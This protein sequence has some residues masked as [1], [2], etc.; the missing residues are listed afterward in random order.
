[1]P[2]SPFAGLEPI[3]N[4]S[5][6]AD[7]AYTALRDAMTGG[8]IPAGTQLSVPEIARRLGISRSPVREA[9]QRLVHDSMATQ[10]WYH[11]AFATPPEADSLTELLTVREPLEGLAAALAAQNA[12]QADIAIL[13]EMV[14]EEGNSPQP[15]TP[16]QAC[17]MG[18]HR[19]IWE[20]AGIRH[21]TDALE[22]LA[23]APGTA[24]PERGDTLSA[25][26]HAHAEHERIVDCIEAGDPPCAEQAAREHI[27]RAR[28]RLQRTL[29]S[30]PALNG[31]DVPG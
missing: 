2:A 7:R 25:E 24:W 21:L 29:R 26:P 23:A 3:P 28:V 9:V 17:S 30:R 8:L 27:A 15:R 16:P 20:I 19:R 1:M 13:H 14:A 18:L 10:D 22:S 31:Q 6:I 5:Q 4:G 12:S 11:G